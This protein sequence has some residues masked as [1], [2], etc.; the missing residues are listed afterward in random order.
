MRPSAYFGCLANMALA[1]VLHSAEPRPVPQNL[2]GGI[3]AIPTTNIH[4][5]F[6]LT[7]NVF[8]GSSP[9]DEAGFAEL[10]RMRIKTIIS[11]DGGKPNVELAHKYGMR[12]VHIPHGYDGIHPNVQA[13][14][15]KAARLSPGANLV[16]CHHGLHRGPAA[17][18]VIC[19]ANGGW[20]PAVGEQWLQ[21]AGTGSNYGGL[22]QTVRQ[23]QKPSDER[24]RAL[25]SG[26]PE[27][28]QVSGLVDAMVGI[29]ERWDHLK[30]V[31]KAG[32]QKSK[33]HPDI[34]PAH[35]AVILWEHY[36]EAQRLPDAAQHGA[37]FVDLL[38]TAEA[39]A[40]EAETLL[41]AFATAPTPDA[42]AKLDK[43]FD[44]MARTC[45]SCHKTYRD[46][47][48]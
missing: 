35:E 19:M 30:A 1:I 20:S 38:K 37:K 40:K 23:F 5:T 22:Y 18:A 8:A 26:F 10:A 34:E 14:L 7:T 25:P 3:R 45:A 2:P 13:Q 12:Y 43:T 4:N 31:R 21:A 39:E 27:V 47:K 6:Q 28:A 48:N 42:R 32:Y 36:R 11:V 41:R 17:A 33:E 16:H 29:D 46:R 9:D 24:L 15:V 44:V